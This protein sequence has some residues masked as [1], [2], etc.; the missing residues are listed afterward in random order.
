M[1]GEFIGAGGGCGT[2]TLDAVEGA[3]GGLLLFEQPFVPTVSAATRA[4]ATS[5][6]LRASAPAEGC[7]FFAG[8][9]GCGAFDPP[10]VC[11]TGFCAG[12]LPES[13]CKLSCVNCDI[14][15][16]V[17]DFPVTE[18]KAWRRPFQSMLITKE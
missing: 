16:S 10:G 2:E 13:P 9:L 14:L 6:P 8:W 3:I 7:C 11:E 18:R 5:V 1:T 15:A 12:L 4:A 17:L